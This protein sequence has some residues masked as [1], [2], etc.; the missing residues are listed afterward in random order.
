MYCVLI[1]IFTVGIMT[2]ILGQAVFGQD[3]EPDYTKGKKLEGNTYWALGPT[4]LIGYIWSKR[5]NTSDTWMILIKE[6]HK[7]SP[8]DGKIQV[9]DVIMGV[10]TA[11]KADARKTLSAAITEAEKS[12][13]KGALKLLVWRK[14]KTGVISLKLPVRGTFS[15]TAPYNCKKTEALREATAKS[16]VEE[17]FYNKDGRHKGKIRPDLSIKVNA[18]GLL[19]TGDQKYMPLMQKYVRQIADPNI[20]LDI[21]K[22]GMGSWHWSYTAILI[23]EYYMLTKDKAVLPALTEYAT[24][25]A[26]G[27]SGVG[28]WGHGMAH[29][30]L[31]YGML[32]GAP[33]GYG[34]MNQCS[35][36]CALALVLAQ[37][38][39]VRN[40]EID[41]AVIARTDALI[42]KKI[43]DV[44]CYKQWTV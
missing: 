36:T 23:A 12:E 1:R 32:H 22:R 16:I 9:G 15:K 21:D 43:L 25:L 8:A 24:K 40:K 4:G 7:G 18:L 41:T 28:T 33:T 17:G 20:K 27:Q 19:A 31:N 34:A 39:G 37:K 26:M 14:G 5:G 30:H 11:F 10:G 3:K 38:C 29:P 2:V 6:V 13:N 44:K 35:L 42:G